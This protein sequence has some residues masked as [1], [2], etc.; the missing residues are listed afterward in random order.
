MTLEPQFRRICRNPAFAHKTYSIQNLQARGVTNRVSFSNA[1]YDASFNLNDPEQ[2]AIQAKIDI[3]RSM[4]ADNPL[5]CREKDG[6]VKTQVA[7]HSRAVREMEKRPTADEK[8]T[9][10]DI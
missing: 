10:W 5:T 1:R 4:H 8:P 6:L 3:L 2:A 9:S 7:E